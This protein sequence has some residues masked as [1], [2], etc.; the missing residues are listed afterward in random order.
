MLERSSSEPCIDGHFS[1]TR[2]LSLKKFLNTPKPPCRLP[3][4]KPKSSGRVL[5]SLEN[6]KVM[7]EREEKKR[8]EARL[9]E[10]RKRA[11]EEKKKL[12]EALEKEKARNEELKSGKSNE[13][14]SGTHTCTSKR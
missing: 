12:K 14:K 1:L 4:A 7:E 10:E 13:H 3:T 5:T 11:R 6:L 9:K 2:Q 8:E